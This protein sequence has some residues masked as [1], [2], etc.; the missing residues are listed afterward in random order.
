MRRAL[1][2][3]VLPSLLA[4]QEVTA[5]YPAPVEREASRL[6]TRILSPYCP[7]LTLTTCPSPEAEVLRDSIRAEL[8]AGRTPADV[9]D[10]LE[11]R[12]GPG[13]HASPPRRGVGLL[14]WAAPAFVLALA[15]LLLTRWLRRAAR[16]TRPAAAA[17]PPALDPAAQSR[18]EQ[19]LRDES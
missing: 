18:L 5:R 10:D 1:L 17:A 3:L 13:I 19:A 9:L 2:L 8:A 11:A 4:A 14:A 16:A 7:G 6:F 15:A 12:F